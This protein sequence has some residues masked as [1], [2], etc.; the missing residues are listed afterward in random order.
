MRYYEE[1]GRIIGKTPL[2][3]MGRTNPYPNVLILA[4]LERMNPGGSV[5]DRIALSMLE[6][7]E[8]NGFLKPDKIIIEPTSG[9]TG[10]GL[11]MICAS[12][13]YKCEFVMPESMS[14]ERRKII[15]AYGAQV[16]LT[17]AEEGVDGPRKYVKRKLAEEPDKYFSPNQYDNPAN[18]KAH[19]ETTAKE[20]LDDTDFKI[21]HFI[22]G[23]GTSGTL[24][25][26]SR[27]LKEELENVVIVSVEPDNESFIQGLRDL[28]RS[29]TPSIFDPSLLD[30]RIRVSGFEA[31]CTAR[32]LTKE[33]GLFVGKSSG[34]AMRGA[35]RVAKELH[36]S[37]V[38]D[39]VIVVLLPDSGERYL[40]G[41][42]YASTLQA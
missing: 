27:R 34:A 21:T 3:K 9:N 8:R 4:K 40:S 30:R 41:T 37:G 39:A 20:I 28:E 6:D 17:P 14:I 18:W 36:E 12:K 25:G 10:I 32:N 15:A 11:A 16:T 35:L 31:E 19:Y 33:E 42:S 24:M 5:K 22:G 29:D 13:G 23:L 38:D 7:A 26:V 2:I 1:I